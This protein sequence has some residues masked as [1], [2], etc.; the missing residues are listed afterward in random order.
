MQEEKSMKLIYQN[1]DGLD[2]TFQ[3]I[4]SKAILS[5]LEEAKLKAQ[6]NKKDCLIKLG[7][8]QLPV[9]VAETGA[10]G[11]YRYRFNTGMDGETWMVADSTNNECWNVRV[12]VS[13]LGLALNG[14]AKTKE[15]LYQ[16]LKQL[17]ASGIAQTESGLL[18]RI[19]RFDYCFDF[20]TED[21]FKPDP[22][23]LIAHQRCNKHCHSDKEVVKA[24][25]NATGDHVNTLRVGEMPGRQ[26]TIYNKSLEIKV[27]GK[28]Y[29][30]KIWRLD[31]LPPGTVWRLEVRVGKDEMDKWGFKR[32]ADFE[33][34]AGDV[35]AH[36]LHIMR[37]VTFKRDSNRSR[38]PLA[39]F[40]QTAI[41]Q[42]AEVLAP[43]SSKATR[44]VILRDNRLSVL[45]RYKT[46]ILGSLIGYIA[47][48]DR[49]ISE[50]ETVLEEFAKEVRGMGVQA[51]EKL[52][53]KFR[54]AEEK[55]R[56]LT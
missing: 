32:F 19:S 35:V 20:H 26:I 48:A 13:S 31:E 7:P 43:Y 54:L 4:V 23:L 21:E 39:S 11:G 49:D 3:G 17:E 42:A 53:A 46:L 25:F 41:H 2:V 52:L 24:Y 56:F 14:Y 1:F 34:K 10:P 29:W 38:W 50:I 18:E 16:R 30:P 6:E 45:G 28:S 36:T 15:R 33:A 9:M 47:A 27:S 55:F 44:E 5:Q 37:Y 51:R 40:W 22:A 12:S 8:D